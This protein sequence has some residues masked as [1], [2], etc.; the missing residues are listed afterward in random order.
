MNE[1]AMGLYRSVQQ[2]T[3]GKQSS[4]SPTSLQRIHSSTRS[5]AA[6]EY[7]QIHPSTKH[8]SVRSSQHEHVHGPLP[9]AHLLVC[10]RVERT[11]QGKNFSWGLWLAAFQDR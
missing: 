11:R 6:R 2:R 4:A 8:H 1:V 9:V 10:S 7:P 5:A 3:T